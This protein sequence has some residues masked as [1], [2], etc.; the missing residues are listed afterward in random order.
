MPNC[1]GGCVQRKASSP[2]HLQMPHSDGLHCEP[3]DVLRDKSVKR[4]TLYIVWLAFV[5]DCLVGPFTLHSYRA[6]CGCVAV[7]CLALS[8]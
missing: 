1:G 6:S 5:A 8:R 7:G 3:N 2:L 4:I